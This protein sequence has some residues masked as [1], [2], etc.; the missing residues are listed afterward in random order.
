MGQWQPWLLAFPPEIKGTPQVWPISVG[1]EGELT[2]IIL[3]DGSTG[4]DVIPRPLP[5]ILQL[6]IP[7]LGMASDT[8]VDT[9][10]Q[11]SRTRCWPIGLAAMSEKVA[12]KAQL[13]SDRHVLEL[14]Q[15]AIK[16]ERHPRVLELVDLLYL[17]K[18]WDLALQLVRHSKLALLANRIEEARDLKSCGKV[19]GHE[20]GKGLASHITDPII[21]TPRIM[22]R[23]AAISIDQ[24]IRMASTETPSPA[25]ML[26]TLTPSA[27]TVAAPKGSEGQLFA[28]A[29]AVISSGGLVSADA[30]GSGAN[31]QE[32]VLSFSANLP[33]SLSRL[34]VAHGGQEY[35]APSKPVARK[36]ADVLKSVEQSTSGSAAAADSQLP[37]AKRSKEQ[38]LDSRSTASV[39]KQTDLS[40]FKQSIFSNSHSEQRGSQ[41]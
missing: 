29:D 11:A 10:E 13:T 33:V 1:G 14:I 18:S 8:T 28:P 32:G 34:S 23:E 19:D 35:P 39:K 40:A 16:A 22:S 27:A 31:A 15:L 37:I 41:Q 21:R 17:E 38:S 25:T 30:S 5:T 26:S 20:G 7:L 6:R 36:L 4:P 9:F 12:K 3:S 24:S 2:G